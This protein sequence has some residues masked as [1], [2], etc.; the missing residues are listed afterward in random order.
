MRLLLLFLF[1]YSCFS[2]GQNEKTKKI[3]TDLLVEEIELKRIHLIL[4]LI[5][6][7]NEDYDLKEDLILLKELIEL[8]RK[9]QIPK[10]LINGYM[11][12]AIFSC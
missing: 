1:F 7:T 12:Q 8:S 9:N 6:T 2:F 4:E 3:K 5:D 10:G 11:Y